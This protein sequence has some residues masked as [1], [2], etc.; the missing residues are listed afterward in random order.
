MKI[1]GR[2]LHHI[3]RHKCHPKHSFL[4]AYC[5]PT[6]TLLFIIIMSETGVWYHRVFSSPPPSSWFYLLQILTLWVVK[7]LIRY[8]CWRSATFILLLQEKN[9]AER[10]PPFPSRL[11]IIIVYVQQNCSRHWRKKST[12]SSLSLI[13]INAIS[14]LKNLCVCEC[15][16]KTK[17]MISL[18]CFTN[19]CAQK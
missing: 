5:A 12:P 7:K 2:A 9:P 4:G 19:E 6:N 3:I 15:V 13:M 17:I 1:L 11:I 14:P 18:L 16:L 8:C 10:P